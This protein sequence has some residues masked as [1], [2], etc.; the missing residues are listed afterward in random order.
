MM[1]S[2]LGSLLRAFVSPP[3]R[4]AGGRSH[5]AV[6]WLCPQ[7]PGEKTQFTQ[8]DRPPGHPRVALLPVWVSS[9]K[10]RRPGEPSPSLHPELTCLCPETQLPVPLCWCLSGEAYTQ[11]KARDQDVQEVEVGGGHLSKPDG[12]CNLPGQA[13]SPTWG[14][15]FRLLRTPVRPENKFIS[16]C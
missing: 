4:L 14:P 16:G 11:K 5:S 6:T 9:L 1:G 7:T 10:G 3:V 2:P 15:G 13:G 12:L 8:R